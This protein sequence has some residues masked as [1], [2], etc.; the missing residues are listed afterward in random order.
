MKSGSFDGIANKFDKNIYGTSKGRL[1]HALLTHYLSDTLENPAALEVLDAGGG[2]GMMSYEFAK[3]G[4]AVDV[5]DISTEALDIARVKLAEFTST[6]FICGGVDTLNKKYDVIVCHALLE[7]LDE[8]LQTLLCLIGHLRENGVLSLSFF[9]A[10]AMLFNNAIYGN[11]DYIAKGMKVRNAVRLN[12][13]NPQSPRAVIDALSN[14]ADVKI[15]LQAGIRCFHDYM[16]DTSMQNSHFDQILS[17]E[18][19]YGTQAP[20]MWLGKY[21]YIRLKKI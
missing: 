4:H 16:R 7:W 1:R 2:T 15:E 21:F 11:F 17:L 5:L 20:Y 9:N 10:D 13:H 8:P 18:K 14:V 6:N 3:H 19:R 12:P